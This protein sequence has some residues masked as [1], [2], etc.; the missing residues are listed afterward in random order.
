MENVYQYGFKITRSSNAES[1]KTADITHAFNYRLWYRIL[2]C[3]RTSILMS[4]CCVLMYFIM[5]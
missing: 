4:I 1:L 2:K 3:V 5:H